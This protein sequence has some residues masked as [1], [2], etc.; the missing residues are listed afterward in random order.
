[1]EHT[2]Q[3]YRFD[4]FKPISSLLCFGYQKQIGEK[5]DVNIHLKWTTETKGM[6]FSIHENSFASNLIQILWLV[7][8]YSGQCWKLCSVFFPPQLKLIPNWL[9]I[10]ILNENHL[11]A[12]HLYDIKAKEVI[13]ICRHFHLPLF[14]KESQWTLMNDAAMFIIC[15]SRHRPH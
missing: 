14:F 8:H 4:N 1:M 9:I 3:T 12:K 7:S 2:K 6:L 13:N 15:Q 5:K 10:E 11:K